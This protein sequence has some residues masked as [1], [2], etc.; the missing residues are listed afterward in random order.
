[1]TV[2]D[3]ARHS[4]E[5]PSEER[6]VPTVRRSRSDRAYRLA[7]SG[8]GTLTLVLM[9]LIGLFLLVRGWDT[10]QA[11]GWSFFTETQWNPETG[12][13]GIAS[14]LLGTVLI[15]GV[16]LIIAFPIAIGTALFITE[17]A[18]ASAAAAA[19]V[20]GRPARR[21]PEPHLRPLGSRSSCS[22]AHD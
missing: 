20:A 1:M 10:L 12:S 21:G 6:L 17:Y 22:R 8:A 16:A 9:G 4:A 7:A 15:A 11:Q 19:H 3:T 2:I 18:P 5:P 13:F 14:A